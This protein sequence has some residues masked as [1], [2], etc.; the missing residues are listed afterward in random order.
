MTIDYM[1]LFDAAQG[2]GAIGGG[3]AYAGNISDRGQQYADEMGTLAGQ[4]ANDS[5][6]QGY[7]VKTGL[8]TSSVGQ[9]GSVD[10]NAGQNTALSGGAGGYTTGMGTMQNAADMYQTAQH[11]PYSGMATDLLSNN[12]QNPY[13]SEGYSGTR[14]AQNGLMANQMANYGAADQFRNQSMQSTAGREQD[15]YNR[16]MAMQQPGLDSQRAQTNAM[17]YASGRGGVMGSQFGGSGEDAAMARAQAQAQNAASF[18]AMGQAS[19]EQMNQA[20]MANMFGAQGIQAAGLQG[21]LGNQFNQMGLQNAQLGQAA[22][23]TLGQ[24]GNQNMQIKQ[25]AAQGLA[26]VGNQQAGMGLNAYGQSFLPMQNQLQ[27]LQAGQNN[28]AMAQTGQLTGTGYGAQLGLGGIQTA[29][30]ADKASSEL[31]GNL[32]A[33]VLNNSNQQNADGS[34]NSIVGGLLSALGIS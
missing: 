18:Q 16:A 14:G 11:N 12:A 3:I 8:G 23:A 26:N 28:A 4:L 7:T 34:S 24:L 13:T 27:A 33:A 19:Q 20:N 30:N 32:M 9:D 2:L 5:Q 22:G 17:E 10:L 1:G 21:Q 25:G 31:Y 6:F 29:V 15:I